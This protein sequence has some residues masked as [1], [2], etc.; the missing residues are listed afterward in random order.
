MTA[1]AVRDKTDPEKSRLIIGCGYL[2]K[3]V[4]ARWRERGLRV[5]ATTRR[6]EQELRDAGLVPILADVLKQDS[7][8]PLPQVTTVVQCVGFDRGSRDSLKDVYIIGLANVLSRLP[9]E[10]KLIYVSSTGVYGPADDEEVDE[11][12]TPAPTD[13]VGEL[14][15][16]AEE[17]LRA[18]RPDAIILRFAGIYGPGRL[19][20]ERAVRRGEPLATDPDAWLNLIHV[21]DGAAAVLAAEENG[22]P[23]QVYNVADGQPVH[24]GDF[25]RRMAEV[26]G[27]P[28]PRFLPEDHES[29]RGHRRISNRKMVE[30]L[31]VMLRFSSAEDGLAEARLSASANG[32]AHEP[33]KPAPAAS[34]QQIPELAQIE[35]NAFRG[36]LED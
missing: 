32:K 23:G 2:G 4:A 20:R 19:P 5:F 17:L 13:E 34:P 7:I 3:R 10:S 24:R 28:E 31:G 33:R 36:L 26:L 8:P 30:N 16:Q 21:E 1:K 29:G 12:T 15:F 22:V 11:T 6:R 14:V 18:E 25:F 9:P 35:E 27:A